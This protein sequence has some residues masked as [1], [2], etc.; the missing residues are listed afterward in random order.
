MAEFQLLAEP[1]RPVGSRPARRLRA[2]GRVPAIVYGRGVDPVPVTVKARDLRAALSTEAGLN[3]VLSLQVEDKSY[4][5]MARE[6]Q[7]HPVRGTVVHVDF[8]V[9]DPNR[10][11]SADVPISLV[12]EAVELHRADGVLDQQLFGLPVMARPADIPPHLEVDISAL[13]IGTVIRVSEIALPDGVRTD[14]DPESVV[15]A[16]QPPRVQIEELEGAEA[17]EGEAEGE[18]AAASDAGESGAAASGG[19]GRDTEGSS[20]GASEG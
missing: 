2:D 5:T 4:L 20:S 3:A 19:A 16:G 1:G 18:A 7:R 14:L 10:E 9:V 17:A 11:I 15:V 12:G 13:A 6:L 8:Q